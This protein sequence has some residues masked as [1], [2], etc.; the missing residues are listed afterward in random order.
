MEKPRSENKV[1]GVVIAV[2]VG[3]IILSASGGG[4]NTPDHCTTMDF[5]TGAC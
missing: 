5:K 3:L 1:I 4:S 2:V